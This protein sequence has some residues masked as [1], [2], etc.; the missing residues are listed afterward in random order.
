M[1]RVASAL[2]TTT[3]LAVLA[4]ACGGSTRAPVAPPSNTPTGPIAAAPPS[5]AGTYSAPHTVMMVCSENADGWC[6]E[7]VAD[8]MTVIDAGD[9]R[10][11]V[12][13]DL[14]QTNGHTCT[15]S[16]AL[17]LD[18]AASTRRW[19]HHSDDPDEGACDLSLEHAD[20]E[21]RLASE[22]CRYYCGARASLDA[23]FPYPPG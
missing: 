17:T 20:A 18:T 23:T 11:D 14:V 22:G 12:T 15:F 3:A 13:I 16:G 8:A 4:T 10:L 21:L 1:L 2:L 7:S 19:V 6:E 5:I 9:D